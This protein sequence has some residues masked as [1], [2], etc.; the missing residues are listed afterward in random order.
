MLP[1]NVMGHVS[2]CEACRRFQERVQVLDNALGTDCSGESERIEHLHTRI[3]ASVKEA[4]SETSDMG[5]AHGRLALISGIVGVTLI[6]V[7]A[8]TMLRFSRESR[9]ELVGNDVS[10]DVPA[11]DVDGYRRAVAQAASDASVAATFPIS[12]E[13]ENLK[14]D[15]A[16]AGKYLMACLD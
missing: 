9:V 1:E 16:A 12:E 13:M 5:L 4:E 6:A 7:L 11:A 2:E 3:M 15:V 14:S 8:T 10:I